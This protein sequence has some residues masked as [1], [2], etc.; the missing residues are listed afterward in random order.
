MR[1]TEGMPSIPALVEP[2]MLIW[3]RRSANLERLA[4]ARKIQVTEDQ[5]E[6]WEDGSSKPSIPQ[7]RKTAQAYNR[8]LAVFYLPE[9]P[10]DFDTIRDFRRLTPGVSH[11]W[12]AALYAEIRRAH[13]Q[14][15]TLLEIAELDDEPIAANW[16][17]RGD[18]DD[19]LA[20]SARNI[21]REHALFKPPPPSASEYEHLNYW[22]SGAEES[23]ILVMTTEGGK[24][25]VTEARGFSLY[26]DVVPV[27][28]LNGADSPRPRLFSLLHEYAHLLLRTEGVCDVSTDSHPESDARQLEARCNALAAAM[29][30]PGHEVR[31]LDLVAEHD[32]TWAL[33]ELLEVARQF[34][35][36]AEA[37]L[38]RL[39]TLGL[40]S[41]TEYRAFRATN[42]GP[43]SAKKSGKGNANFTKVRDLGKAYVRRVTD[44][45]DRAVIDTHTTATYLDA[46][47][48]RIPALARAARVRA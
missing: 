4:A 38:R 14:R 34:G 45:H 5:I 8:P 43:P 44:A 41:M 27:I 10:Q 47:V 33:P 24:V 36:S 29:L 18:S 22:T 21:L 48:E 12:S 30:M 31:G 3:A 13:T 17:A 28:M 6:G 25:S 20:A 1:K 19:G 7:L 2:E 46:K 26:D 11:E 40:A 15:E 39:V 9:P 35:S 42:P 16:R 32:G 23:G 37:M